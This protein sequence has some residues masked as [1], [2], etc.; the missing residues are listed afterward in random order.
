M[1]DIRCLDFSH[2][3]RFPGTSIPREP[4]ATCKA[5][6]DLASQVRPLPVSQATGDGLGSGGGSVAPP[7]RWESRKELAAGMYLPHPFGRE[8]PGASSLPRSSWCPQILAWD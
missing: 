4:G 3:S 5:S 7:P 8:T 6:S 2:D 1:T